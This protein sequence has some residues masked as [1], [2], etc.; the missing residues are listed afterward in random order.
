VF[1][2]ESEGED[3][4]RTFRMR[5]VSAAD[6]LPGALVPITSGLAAGEEVVT[7]GAVFV[8]GQASM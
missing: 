3:G 4:V 7:R 5:R 8:F 2:A 1:V 6:D